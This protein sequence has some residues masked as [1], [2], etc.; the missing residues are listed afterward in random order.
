MYGNFAAGIQG[1]FPATLSSLTANLKKMG[2]RIGMVFS[3]VG[4]AC[5]TGSQLAGV[6]I[7]RKQ[8]DYLYAQIFGGSVVICSSLLL[9]AARV[10]QTGFKFKQR[11]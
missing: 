1:L 10:V 2:V 3:I 6:L 7:Q 4:V 11:M 8:G 9:V 5:L